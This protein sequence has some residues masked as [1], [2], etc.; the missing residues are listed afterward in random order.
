MASLPQLKNLT[1][2]VLRKDESGAMK[3]VELSATV[4]KVK[5]AQ[6]HLL[7]FDPDA[8]PEQLAL[9]DSWLKP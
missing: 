9:R 5:L 7:G 8:T 1:Y 3:E 4:R 6:R 2:T